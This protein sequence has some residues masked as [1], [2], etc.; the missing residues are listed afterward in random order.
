MIQH[1]RVHL[2][3]IFVSLFMISLGVDA[4]VIVSLKTEPQVRDLPDTFLQDQIE[5]QGRRD[6][7]LQAQ[8]KIDLKTKSAN[9]KKA[10][11]YYEKG[12]EIFKTGDYANSQKYFA[13][14]VS[15]DAS[16]DQYYHEYAIALYK[17]ANYRRSIALLGILDGGDVSEVELQY[18]AGLNYF[19][20]KQMD[21]ALRKFKT[22]QEMEDPTLSP[23]AAMYTGLSYS[24]LEKY[25]DAKSSFQY[26]LD[27]SNDA[28]LDRQ[29][30]AY[31]ESIER[32]ESFQKEAAK[33]W[34][35][36]LFA[37]TSY[38]ENVLNAAAT[39]NTTTGAEAYR[40]LYGG[41]LSYK[42][43][44]LQNKSLIPTL[45]ISDIY[46]FNKDF[47]AD[48]TIQ[49]T[50]PLQIDFS[51]PFRYSFPWLSKNF[52]L[53]LTP[54]Y[55]NLFMS[56]GNSNR[57]LTFSSAYLYSQISTSHF[58]NLYTDYKFNFSS[59]TS[60]LTPATPA[61]DQ[62]AQKMTLGLT[63]TY[64]FNK[65]G[66]Q[67]IF[68]DLY[69][70][71]NNADGDNNIY[72]KTLGN[73]GYSHPLTDSWILFGKFEYFHQD[74]KDS[75]SGRVDDNITATIGGYYSLSEKN[76][77]SV[78]AL[79]MDNSSSVSYFTYDK[80]AVTTTWSFNSSFF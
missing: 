23:L 47:E 19:K 44:Y 65:K 55:L 60:H 53:S 51:S 13:K 71:M 49:G 22:T 54:G 48:A 35:Y 20:M 36:T 67:T 9:Q 77:L 61:D 41:S 6:L 7:L 80:F 8:K 64:M 58:E 16:V 78:S 42:A 31:I 50:D 39:N 70:V 62:S 26:V 1:P 32:Y 73:I 29:A 59:D 37:G 21:S 40:L 11:L 28:E 30:E 79:Y 5:E 63:N 69:Y 24:Q 14:A 46:S 38:D 72:L 10:R 76:T 52:T 68:S 12:R 56:L 45:S 2:V 33:K 15:L 4:G 3:F 34:A 57:E 74:F 43:L 17:N 18:Y 66:T 27:T 25:S 75:S